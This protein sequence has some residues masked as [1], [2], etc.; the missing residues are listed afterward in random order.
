MD[1]YYLNSGKNIAKIYKGNYIDT[2]RFS[3][4]SPRFWSYKIRQALTDI[5]DP[6]VVL[7]LDD[8]LLAR[9]LEI[10]NYENLLSAITNDS[11][12]VCAH[13]SISPERQQNSHF[14][15]SKNTLGIFELPKDSPYLISTQYSIWRRE[16]LLQILDKVRTPWEFEV[17][18]TGI[19]SK[20]Q[21]AK[22]VQ[23]FPPALAYPEP[24]ALSARSPGLVSVL[25]NNVS[26]IL[27][28]I[29]MGHLEINK[30]ILGQ[31]VGEKKK[32]KEF[33]FNLEGALIAC[34]SEEL[35]Y[36]R[37]MLSQCLGC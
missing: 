25:G 22:V 31:W 26:D 35:R 8:F 11:D 21:N 14:V 23:S 1:V 7:A 10:K 32:F 19:V 33:K 34:P 28:L 36:Y 24:S 16:Y 3:S 20:D 12:I 37:H 5:D 18:G 15:H 29:E 30:L 2:G 9:P 17:F 4:L 27:E 13:L 6:F